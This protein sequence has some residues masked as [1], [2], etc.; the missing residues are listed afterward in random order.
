MQRDI[1]RHTRQHWKGA[2]K[3]KY[4]DARWCTY[5]EMQGK[6][7][8]NARKHTWTYESNSD[9]VQGD[10]PKHARGNSWTHKGTFLVTCKGAHQDMQGNDIPGHAR[11]HSRTVAGFSACLAQIHS[12]A[13]SG[14]QK[15]W[16]V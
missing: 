12:R 8:V 1:L 7:S 14:E 13:G 11:E 5:P 15:T 10:T 4:L 2:C 6:I 9:H 16:R 3:G